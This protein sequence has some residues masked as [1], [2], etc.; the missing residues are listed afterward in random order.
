GRTYIAGI[1]VGVDN[2]SGVVESQVLVSASRFAVLDP[3]GGAVSAP[4]VVQGGQVFI[5]QALIGVGW[6]QSA[7]IGDVIQSTA[8]GANG[9]PRWRLD[10]NGTITL[11][12]ANGGSGYMTLND[13][14][15]LVYDNNGTLRVRLGLW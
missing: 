11:N 15:L 5:S 13:S 2:T 1:G 3:N 14:T 9:Q 7:N 4:F 10:K 6:I 12:G 8:L